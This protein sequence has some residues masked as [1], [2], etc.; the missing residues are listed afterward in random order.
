MADVRAPTRIWLLDYG[1]DE[2]TWCTDPSPSGED[3]GAVEYVRADANPQ[4]DVPWNP[5]GPADD[6]AV[7][8]VARM[9]VKSQF[10]RHGVSWASLYP[11]QRAAFMQD[12]R[13]AIQAL[14]ETV[15]HDAA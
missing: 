7:E 14:Q 15:G 4:A 10:R 12:A 5:K 8:R 6:V 11:D 13:A 1:S 9:L 2:A 3:H